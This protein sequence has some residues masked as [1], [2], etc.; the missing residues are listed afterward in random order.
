M[1]YN[2]T[3]S[4]SFTLVELV[5]VIVLLGI[6]S[7]Y[8][9]PRFVGI[10]DFQSSGFYQE[11]ASATRYA[12]RLAVGRGDK[13]R[14][15]FANN[16]YTLYYQVS[17]SFEKLP[18]SHPVHEGRY[19]NNVNV[20]SDNNNLPVNATFTPLGNCEDCNGDLTITVDGKKITIFEQTGYV[21][22]T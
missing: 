4:P 3:H 2:K 9:I 5:I 12:N 6:V 8:A 10:A 19:P 15:Q 11:L 22:A 20:D 7:F 21:N 17:G 13:V 14:I 18:R 1:I 16:K